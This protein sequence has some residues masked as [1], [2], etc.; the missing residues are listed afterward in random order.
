LKLT[1]QEKQLFDASVSHV[2]ELTSQVD[3][4]L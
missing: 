2:N 1:D 4:L 3:K